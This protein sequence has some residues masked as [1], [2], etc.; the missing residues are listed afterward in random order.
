MVSPSVALLDP[1]WLTGAIYTVLNRAELVQ[2]KGKFERAQ[3]G[4]WLDP[5]L[6]PANRHKFI[7][8]LLNPEWVRRREG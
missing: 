5:A 6:Y 8:A 4:K 3:L 7:L 2:Q 1:N